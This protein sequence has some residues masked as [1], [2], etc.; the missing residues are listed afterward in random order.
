MVAKVTDAARLESSQEATTEVLKQIPR[1]DVAQRAYALFED[2][3]REPGR[4]VDDWLRAEREIEE[5]R[6]QR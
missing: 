2:R 4:D 1:E 5:A 6:R 3:G